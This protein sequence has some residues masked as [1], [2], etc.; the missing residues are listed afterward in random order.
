MT[1]VIRS[2]LATNIDTYSEAIVQASIT[3]DVMTVTATLEGSMEPGNA[4][5][6]DNVQPFSSIVAIIDGTPGA[7]T[8]RIQPAQTVPP[9]LIFAGSKQLQ[10]PTEITYQVE[11][12]GPDS[13]DM[14]QIIS[15]TWRDDFACQF[16][17]GYGLGIQPL[18]ASVPR[19]LPFWSGEKQTTNRWMIDLVLQANPVVSVPQQFAGTAVVGLF[20]VDTTYPPGDT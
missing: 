12:Y 6:G 15:T 5:A 13:A 4:L 10:Q 7:E 17:G 16:L 3:G 11:A 20:E 19:Q 2:R 18:Y 9:G 8:W 14:I 1:Q